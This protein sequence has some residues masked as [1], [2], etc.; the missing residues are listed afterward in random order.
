VFDL[1]DDPAEEW[2]LIQKRLDCIWVL[3]PVARHLGR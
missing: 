2:D 3:G 1:I